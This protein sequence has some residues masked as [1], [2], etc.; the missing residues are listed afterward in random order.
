MDR[1]VPY[2]AI[3]GQL[4]A[5]PVMS[6]HKAVRDSTLVPS[7]TITTDCDLACT[8]AKLPSKRAEESE[9]LR[10][11]WTKWDIFC[12]SCKDNNRLA[13]E[14]EVRALLMQLVA[15]ICVACTVGD[16]LLILSTDLATDGTMTPTS[17]Q[18]D[19][20]TRVK[21]GYF[22]IEEEIVARYGSQRVSAG[23]FN[24]KRKILRALALP[25]LPHDGV[26]AA[27]PITFL[28]G[29]QIFQQVVASANCEHPFTAVARCLNGPKLKTSPSQKTGKV[30]H[31]LSSTAITTLRTLK[32]RQPASSSYLAASHRRSSVVWPTCSLRAGMPVHCINHE[33]YVLW[34]PYSLPFIDTL[35]AI[36]LFI[37]SPWRLECGSGS[38][39]FRKITAQ[40][41]TFSRALFLAH[42][43]ADTALFSKIP[44]PL[45]ADRLSASPNVSRDS[46]QLP[47]L[48]AP[49]VP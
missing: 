45:A 49:P 34:D 1:A 27:Q 2:G 43:D 44:E 41:M 9:P 47:F 36:T 15:T 18:E 14:L 4:D 26:P 35:D 10:Q 33:T 42:V 11:F 48:P 13:D 40:W 22:N 25:T 29:Q 38:S 5:A 28:T 17:G 37:S 3:D 19:R 6:R 32:Y 23:H 7:C 12:K 46:P 39:A 16:S 30:S 8:D 21:Q 31:A 24:T 20:A